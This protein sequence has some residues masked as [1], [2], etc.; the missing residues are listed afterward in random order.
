[1]RRV[2]NVNI[3]QIFVNPRVTYYSENYYFKALINLINCFVQTLILMP[4]L[5]RVEQETIRTDAFI[6]IYPET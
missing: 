6:R 1:M 2:C 4:I 5:F 3:S